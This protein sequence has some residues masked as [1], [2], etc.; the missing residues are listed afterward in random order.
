MMVESGNRFFFTTLRD[1]F[2]FFDWLY[3][4]PKGKDMQGDVAKTLHELL[5]DYY[6]GSELTEGKILSNLTNFLSKVDAFYKKLVSQHVPQEALGTAASIKKGATPEEI[7]YALLECLPKFLAAI[8]YLW[9]CVSHKFESLG[10]GGW[11]DNYPGW[12]EDRSWLGT[13]GWGGD[14]QDYLRAPKRD[15]DRYGGLIPGGFNRYEVRDGWSSGYNRGYSMVTDLKS[16][17]GKLDDQFFRDVF[18]T[19]VLSSAGSERVNTANALALVNEFCDIVA[20]DQTPDGGHL[21]KVLEEEIKEKGSCSINWSL[22]KDHCARLKDSLGKI[23]N[24]KAFSF[25]GYGRKHGELNKEKFAAKTAD[26]LRENLDEVRKNLEKIQQFESEYEG[27]TKQ[28]ASL[29]K[30]HDMLQAYYAELGPHFTKNLFPYGFTFYGGKDY[31]KT[32]A[33]YELVRADW[34]YVIHDLTRDSGNLVEL[35]KILDGRRLRPGLRGLPDLRHHPGLPGLLAGHTVQAVMEGGRLLGVL[36]LVLDEEIQEGEGLTI[37]EGD[38]GLTVEEGGKTVE[39]HGGPQEMEDTT[40]GLEVLQEPGAHREAVFQGIRDLLSLNPYNRKMILGLILN[41]LYLLPPVPIEHLVHRLNN[42]RLQHALRLKPLRLLT[43]ARPAPALRHL[44]SLTPV[45]RNW[46]DSRPLLEIT[47]GDTTPVT[48]SDPPSTP[49]GGGANGAIGVPS[50]G[51]SL[52]ADSKDSVSTSSKSVASPRIDLPQAQSIHRQNS[53]SHGAAGDGDSGRTGSSLPEANSNHD[54]APGKVGTQVGPVP[55]PD[56]KA[57]SGIHPVVSSSARHTQTSN[58]QARDSLSPVVPPPGGAQDLKNQ[59]PSSNPAQQHPQGSQQKLTSGATT[60]SAVSSAGT[61]CDDASGGGGGSAGG[62]EG[63]PLVDNHSSQSP[64]APQLSLQHHTPGH[65]DPEPPSSGIPGPPGGLSVT[66]QSPPLVNPQGDTGDSGGHSPAAIPRA[67]GPDLLSDSDD[68]VTRAQQHV[69][70]RHSG[71]PGQS[72]PALPVP[73]PLPSAPPPNTATDP[74][75]PQSTPHGLKGDQGVQDQGAMQTPDPSLKGDTGST[76]PLNQ[77]ASSS[78]LDAHDPPG[79]SGSGDPDPTSVKLQSPQHDAVHGAVLTQP[80]SVSGPQSSSIAASPPGG[81]KGPDD[82]ASLSDPALTHA[83]NSMAIPGTHPLASPGLPPGQKIGGDA[84][85]GSPGATIGDPN[86]QNRQTVDNNLSSSGTSMNSGSDT[87]HQIPP[88]TSMSDPTQIEFYIEKAYNPEIIDDTDSIQEVPLPAVGHKR[89]VSPSNTYS[90]IP[91]HAPFPETFYP[92]LTTL[93][94]EDKCV[95]PWI[96]KT[97]NDNLQEF[98][99]TELF[100]YEAPRTIRDM[101]IWLVG[102]QNPKHSDVMEKCINDAFKDGIHDSSDFR[103]S[104]NDSSIT[105][106]NVLHTIQL[107]AVFAAS[108]LSAIEP[109]WKGNIALSATLKPKDPEQPKDPD[110]CA[111]LCHLRDY[112]YACH[113]QLAFL[114]SQCSREQSKGGWH[115]HEY[116]HG[117]SPQKSPPPSLPDRRP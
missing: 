116:G 100:P 70:T 71:S 81:G 15:A 90:N 53:L 25:T 34:D 110:Y 109:A 42:F 104:L 36:F 94:F 78:S 47:D 75:T 38:R 57:S 86:L 40:Q 5:R 45:V 77:H 49:G 112:V 64:K 84:G 87:S 111:L 80:S 97:D 23:F 58:V 20:E 83:K 48:R 32:N 95:P 21:K 103:L 13:K 113:H 3:T 76:G 10:G 28:L 114:K 11:K 7:V 51:G 29:P 4:D 105:A 107:A 14:L 9:Y 59:T 108:V 60:T 99:D 24:E 12:E 27:H 65:S 35:K 68:A 62:T 82:Q 89:I 93:E 102:L 56:S 8:Y 17:F 106:D 96:T 26:W 55:G 67:L 37:E 52:G 79:K 2:V 19:S 46:V 101:L 50:T 16:I 115:N 43:Q 73:P 85:S 6:D 31:F 92:K 98:P 1:C 88:Q 54:G 91:P 69:A 39:R 117:V 44:V 61:G 22:L 33:P 41:I 66:L 18:A 30:H 72:G 74:S 63:D